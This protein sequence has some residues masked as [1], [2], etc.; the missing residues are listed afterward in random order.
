MRI[1]ELARLTGA[2]TK[3]LRLY[4]SRQLLPPV[5]RNGSYRD[6]QAIHV[7][8]VLLIRK[9]QALGFKLS[10]MQQIRQ[11]AEGFSWP[12]LLVLLKQKQTQTLKAIQDLQTLNHSL[13]D[14]IHELELCP[15]TISTLETCNDSN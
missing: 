9:A 8:Q 2:S 5:P 12:H 6:Y 7:E 3:A 14:V 4:E 10:E 15:V 11:E 1:S 13:L